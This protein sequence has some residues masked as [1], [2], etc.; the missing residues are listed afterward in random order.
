MASYAAGTSY[1]P[2]GLARV[3]GEEIIELPRGTRVH[4]AQSA[5]G[6]SSTDAGDRGL[7]VI[8]NN[9]NGSKVETKMLRHPG[10]KRELE[11]FILD[12]VRDASRRGAPGF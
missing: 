4:S 1:H 5:A 9:T 12:T 10:G 11:V 7:T 6:M 3:H 8:I 2:G